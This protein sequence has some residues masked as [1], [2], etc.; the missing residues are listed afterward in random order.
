MSSSP[1]ASPLQLR[2]SRRT[3]FFSISLLALL[4]LNLKQRASFVDNL[5]GGGGDASFN[6]GKTKNNHKIVL[7]VTKTSKKDKKNKSSSQKNTTTAVVKARTTKLNKPAKKPR[8][9]TKSSRSQ[10]FNYTAFW[11]AASEAAFASLQQESTSPPTPCPKVYVYTNLKRPLRD[12]HPPRLKT[13]DNTF[14]HKATNNKQYKDY[15]YT[16]NQYSLAT[17]L[18]YRLLH[19][20]ECQTRD[21]NEADLFYAPIISRPKI[22]RRI[23]MACH[24]FNGTTVKDSLKYINNT[25]ACRHFFALGKGHYNAKSCKGWYSYP[26]SELQNT[27][28]LA[29]S[30]FAFHKV[31]GHHTYTQK[32]DKPITTYPHVMSVPYPSSLHFKAVDT[33]NGTLLPQ[34]K[35][36]QKRK[37]LMLFMGSSS[38]GDTPVRRKIAQS[39]RGYRSKSICASPQWNSKTAL[40]KA[41][42]TFCLEP[43][44]DSPWRKSLSDSITFGCIPVLFS[45]LTDNV[46]PW[47]WGDW[48]ARARVLVPRDDFVKKKI[49]LKKLLESIPKN[50][51][52]LMQT[53]LKEKARK[54]QYSIDDDQED[55]IRVILDNLHRTAMEMEQHGKCGYGKETYNKK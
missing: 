1:S 19:S 8:T 14:G 36:S 5:R 15:L 24:E 6:K 9:S 46:A 43:A 44:G 48:K 10:P 37:T 3:R 35:T 34:F 54:F 11:E 53:T 28:R 39:C 31:K 20:P 30:H 23:Y 47:H 2:L 25:N 42:A 4:V 50:L 17:I 26:I 16:T 38:H 52:T 49:D 41:S 51:L 21:P 55:G 32:R 29:Y 7:P 12:G 33:T 18:E 40:A 22:G 13:I 45:E 27:Q